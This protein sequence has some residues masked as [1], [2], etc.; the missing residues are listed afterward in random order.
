MFIVMM[1]LMAIGLVALY[2]IALSQ[3]N[4]DFLIFKKQLI[5]VGLGLIFFIIFAVV[6]YKIWA[7]YY[8]WLLAA[9]L[10]LLIAVLL[11]GVDIRGTRGWL[12]FGSLGFQPV[13]VFKIILVIFLSTYFSR[14]IHE[15]DQFKNIIIST[16]LMFVF[17][18]LVALQP[19]LGAALILFIVW[20]G[21]LMLARVKKHHLAVVLLI[22]IIIAAS[23]W[24]FL[25]DYQKDRIL[26]FLNPSLD[27]Y[28]QG[29]NLKQ[30]IIAVGA[31]Q[32]FGRGVAS[33][34]QSQL[35]FLPESQNDF[36]FAVIAEELG[37]VGA[38]LLLFIFFI[39]FFRFAKIIIRARDEIGSFLVLGIFI[40]FFSQFFV[41]IGMNIGLLPIIGLSLPFVS[42][43]GSGLL[44]GMILMGIAQSVRLRGGGVS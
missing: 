8:L 24:F 20:L 2:S 12:Y 25:H 39:L 37:L 15:M 36:I 14:K 38:I 10:I 18:I 28:G 29:Y 3:E 43:G 42:Y 6:D 41:N 27:P 1:L 5:F 22:L 17:M 34:S 4:P 23:S 35:K 31:G 40:L 9:G 19:D 21:M 7:N 11:F 16:V 30:S 32:L 33:G 26:S 13:E 44:T